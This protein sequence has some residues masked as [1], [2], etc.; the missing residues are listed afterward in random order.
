MVPL[1]FFDIVLC[2]CLICVDIDIDISWGFILDI[3][4]GV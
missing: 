1:M 4:Y 3:A 2:V